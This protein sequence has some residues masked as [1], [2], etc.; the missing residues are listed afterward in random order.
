LVA[1]FQKLSP[2]TKKFIVNA[3]LIAGAIGP[4]IVVLGT[5]AQSIAAVKLAMTAMTGPVGLVIAALTAFVGVVALYGASAKDAD[6]EVEN[7]KKSIEGLSD[8]EAKRFEQNKLRELRDELEQERKVY[9]ALKN[10]VLTGDAVESRIHRQTMERHKMKAEALEETISAIEREIS[11]KEF[12]AEA[13]KRLAVFA[14]DAEVQ[15]KK[16]TAAVSD[17]TEKVGFL[18][19]SL[20]QIKSAPRVGD[21]LGQLTGTDV[22]P[23]VGDLFGQLESASFDAV[24]QKA[25]EAHEESIERMKQKNETFAASIQGLANT[26]QS[27]FTTLF[28]GLL[29]G[30]QSFGDFMKQILMDLL[31]KLASMV[32]AFLIIGAITGGAGVGAGSA[33]GTMGDFLKGGFGI[34]QFAAGGIVSGPT[35]AMVGEYSGASTNP[36]V[37]APLDKLQS[38]MGGAGGNVTVTGRISGR[39]ILLSNERANFERNRTRGF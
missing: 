10:Q 36:E 4:L 21:L 27:Q 3:T 24:M 22:G 31:V 8:A 26:L 11:N 13:D 5:L 33:L 19:T 30:T 25:E 35:L 37:I 34:P 2:E 9:D 29:N 1:R 14:K 12:A 32:A 23:Q 16:N 7:L 28:S 39:D 6:D 38:M 20:N 17:F 15:T 18:L